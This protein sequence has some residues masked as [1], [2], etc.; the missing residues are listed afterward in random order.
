MIFRGSKEAPKNHLFDDSFAIPS[1][2]KQASREKN[3]LYFEMNL[4]FG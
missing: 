2:V 4:T 1:K 3:W